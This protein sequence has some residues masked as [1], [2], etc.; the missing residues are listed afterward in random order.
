[1]REFT[2][3]ELVKYGVICFVPSSLFLQSVD[4]YIWN[5]EKC[6]DIFAIIH[7]RSERQ[8]RHPPHG[9][10]HYLN[11]IFLVRTPLLSLI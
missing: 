4:I 5:E 7:K 2:N 3:T 9:T 10:R 6:N 8:L 11:L 1:M